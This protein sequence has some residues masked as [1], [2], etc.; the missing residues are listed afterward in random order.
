MKLFRLSLRRPGAHWGHSQ[1][2]GEVI[3]RAQSSG[4]ARFVAARA[5]AALAHLTGERWFE[6]AAIA[7]RNP[8]LYRVIKD[9]PGRYEQA[10][11]AQVVSGLARKAAA[12]RRFSIGETG[13]G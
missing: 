12:A 8:L 1:N 13:T 3:V 9:A 4:E 2:H 7:F 11:A 10:C 6:M 5:E